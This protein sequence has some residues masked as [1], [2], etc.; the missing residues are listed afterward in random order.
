MSIKF[1]ITGFIA[2]NEYTSIGKS[3]I[4]LLTGEEV[5]ILP[6]FKKG[7]VYTPEIGELNISYNIEIEESKYY[8]GW[9]G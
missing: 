2:T 5:K 6:V 1:T 3:Y 4:T 7:E 8:E 9:D